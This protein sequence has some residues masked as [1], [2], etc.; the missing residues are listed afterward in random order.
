MTR[1]SVYLLDSNIL[2]ALA[3][4]EHS[5][6]ARAARWFDSRRGT[7]FATCPI[8]QGALFRFHLRMGVG[9]NVDSARELLGRIS[10]L[11]QHDFWP[12]D[13]S[14]LEVVG[15]GIVRH[16]QVTDAYLVALAKKHGGVLAT[17]DEGLAA[18]HAGVELAG[19]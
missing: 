3:T 4:P 9:A 17:M 1:S 18:L 14:Y 11:P 12:D 2:I 7:R 15:K 13:V 10:A 19:E 6:N 5:L 16:R 8:T